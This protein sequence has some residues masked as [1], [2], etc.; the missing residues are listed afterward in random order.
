MKDFKKNKN[1][2][3]ELSKNDFKKR[4]AGSSLGRVWAFVQPLV[5]VVLYYFVFGL[6]FPGRA[7]LLAGG[8]EVPYVL[9]LTAGLVPWFFLNEAITTGANAMKEYD[10]LV[11]KVVF[12][13]GILPFIKTVSASFIHVFFALMLL[14]MYFAYGFK[15]SFQILQLFYYSFCMFMLVLAITYTTSAVTV[16]F[17]DLLQIINILLQIGMW[18][19]PIL[20]HLSDI[21]VKWQWIFRFNPIYYVIEGYR[22]ALFDRTWVHERWLDTLVFWGIVLILFGIGA[23]VFKKLRPL[24]AD[25]L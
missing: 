6:I 8:I 18:G 22:S 13:I 2:I 21:P 4:Y 5:T 25:V 12:K 20:W 10:Y 3:W 16:F 24:F 15:P 11:K 1:L 17:K 9:W 14:V 19:T 7:S 23:Y